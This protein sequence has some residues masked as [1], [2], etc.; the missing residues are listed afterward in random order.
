MSD[1]LRIALVAYLVGALIE[2]LATFKQL[3]YSIPALVKSIEDETPQPISQ[4][5]FNWLVLA[6]IVA[7]SIAGALSWPCRLIH[8][9]I[10]N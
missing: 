5:R 10:K 8:R 9:S 4:S 2:G 3:S 1:W 6:I 7:V